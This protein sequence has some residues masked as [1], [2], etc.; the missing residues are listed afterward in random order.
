M[1]IRQGNDELKAQVNAF[2]KDYRAQGGFEKLG[3]R[4][5]KEMKAE[6]K[7]LGSAFFL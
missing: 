5:L 3:D 4:Y 2:I 1:G 7:R 6:F